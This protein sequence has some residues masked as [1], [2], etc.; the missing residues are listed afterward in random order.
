MNVKIGRGGGSGLNKNGGFTLV[1][2]LVVI[3]II[4]VLIALL[5]PAVQAAREAARRISCTN[6]EKQWGIALH[7]FHDTNGVLPP[8]GTQYAPNPTG[9]TAADQ[10]KTDGGPG[11]LARTLPF[12]EAANVSAGMDFSISIFN[13][14][15]SSVNSYY[16][17][18]K[19]IKL[20]IINCPSDGESTMSNSTIGTTAPGSYMVCTGSGT[21]D[22]SL[23][24]VK[25][26]GVFYKARNS[27]NT[28]TGE[29]VKVVGDHGLESMTDGTSNTMMISEAL[30][31]NSTLVGGIDL[32]SMDAASKAKI[33][34]RAIL[35]GTQTPTA[36]AVTNED[37]VTFSANTTK[38]GGKQE[39][40]GMWLSCR[41]DHSAYNAYLTPNQK[42]AC[43]WWKK[44]A[45]AEGSGNAGCF[46]KATSGHPGGVNV[47]YG[48]GS[49]HFISDT[50]NRLVWGN[51]STPDRELTDADYQP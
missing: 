5:L 15:G 23:Q 10:V 27:A 20:A 36:D 38:T 42:D 46:L 39:R 47:C 35:D 22:N 16:N 1:E 40:A 8:H 28:T 4:G 2:L 30:F 3:A 45:P 34:Q 51:L 17:D 33:F 13:G 6:N 12:I 26:D 19:Q 11:A 32:S 37:M 29:V 48:D 44:G 25:T 21:G 18:V 41:W 49:I 50:I 43:N 31:G 7:N 9:A 14:T 24:Q